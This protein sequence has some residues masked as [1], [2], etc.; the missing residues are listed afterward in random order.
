MSMSDASAALIDVRDR[1]RGNPTVRVRSDAAKH[2]GDLLSSESLAPA[3][4]EAALAILEELARDVEQEVRKSLA[5]HVASCAILAPMLARTIAADLETISIPFIQLSPALSESDLVSIARLGSAAKQVAV[6]TRERV[7][8]RVTKVLVATRTAAVVAALLRN[9]GAEISEPSYHMIMD[10]FASD[11]AVQGLLVE[12]AALPLTVTERLIQVVSAGLRNRLIEKHALPPEIATE[13]L[14]QA[15][16]RAL[17]HGAASAPRAFNVEAF[18]IRLNSKGKLTPT[19]L[20]RALCLGDLP[21][22]ESGMAVRAGIAASN[23]SELVA[24]RGPLGFKGLYEKARLPAELFRAFRAALD[25]IGEMRE[26]GQDLW[27][28]ATTQLILD[29]VMRAYDEACPSGLE[30][31]L[32]QMSRQILGRADQHSRS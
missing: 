12:R 16:E 2:V 20:M 13:L 19:L 18:A 1:L 24:D 3:E 14:N 15:R 29:R 28:P 5:I 7:S 9:R 10:G 32:S 11:T 30:Y 4:R 21:F 27:S 26:G 31:L 17:F 8:G 25:V 23:A 22:F 6:A